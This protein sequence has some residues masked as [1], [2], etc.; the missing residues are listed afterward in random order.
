MEFIDETEKIVP[1]SLLGFNVT[2]KSS[3]VPATLCVALSVSFEF[4]EQTPC[5]N[6]SSQGGCEWSF[7]SYVPAN[8]NNY[9][10]SICQHNDFAAS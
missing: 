4:L 9:H 10:G 2:L 5:G 6:P 8:C 1:R 3:K 7:F